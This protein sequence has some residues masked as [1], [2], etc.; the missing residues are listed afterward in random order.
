MVR[1]LPKPYRVYRKRSRMSMSAAVKL[2]PVQE[3]YDDL[4][5]RTLSR[6]SCDLGRLIYLASTRDYNTGNYYHEGLVSRFS[7]EVARKALEIAHR[8]AFYRVSAF[9]LEDLVSDLEAY[10]R[11]T[12]ENPQEFLRA[13]QKL[14]PYRVAIPTEVNLTV[15][16][17][18]TS[19]VR[20]ALAILRF[21][22]EPSHSRR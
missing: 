14:E 12:R 11:S 1:D 20:L 9:S 5:N 18:F 2:V 19:N 4:L 17:L 13:W 7:P 8:Q 21:R 6:V 10:M 15:A 3:A 22:Q 16:R